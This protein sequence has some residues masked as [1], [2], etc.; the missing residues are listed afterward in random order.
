MPFWANSLRRATSYRAASFLRN[1]IPITGGTFGGQELNGTAF[2]GGADF[3]LT[4]TSE[5]H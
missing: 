4:A 1:I 2:S 5:A 3:Q